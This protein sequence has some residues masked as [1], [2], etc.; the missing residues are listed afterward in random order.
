MAFAFLVVPLLGCGSRNDS[1]PTSTRETSRQSSAAAVKTEPKASLDRDREIEK[2]E[3]LAQQR[4]IDGAA[5][6]L[7]ALLLADP[8]DVEVIFRLAS[9]RAFDGD[10]SSAVELL[11][12]IPTDH[13]EAGIPALG[14]S[15]DWCF[16]LERWNDA[17]RRYRKILELLP[18]ASEAHRKLAMLLNR[19]GRRHEAA[20]HIRKLCKQGNVRQDELHA[21]I[22]LSD[23]MYD[24]PSR[25]G[26]ESVFA[27]RPRGT[28]EKAIHGREVP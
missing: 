17:E 26:R 23:A 28:G 4:D 12:S 9:L 24:D 14:Q 8:E 19:Q 15:A 22:H 20:S 27:D 3:Q 21:L 25:P 2:A 18:Q 16:Q 7:K 5:S 10:L 1:P 6:T 13:P 11:D